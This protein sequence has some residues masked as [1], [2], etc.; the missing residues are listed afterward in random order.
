MPGTP[1]ES[2]DNA[3]GQ[4]AKPR[5][6]S[7][8]PE[9]APARLFGKERAENNE[10]QT[11]RTGERWRNHPVRGR[12]PAK[13]GDEGLCHQEQNDGTN[14]RKRVPHRRDAPEPHLTRNGANST[15]SRI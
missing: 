10:V 9:S 5:L 12:C 11:A 3:G 14:E 15:R 2:D 4:R 7:R 8:L 1:D 6:K 13:P